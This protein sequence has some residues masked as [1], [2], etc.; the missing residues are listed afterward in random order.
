ME[1]RLGLCLVTGVEDVQAKYILGLGLAQILSGRTK[2]GPL[3]S[4]M[5]KH[6]VCV[7]VRMSVPLQS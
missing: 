3:I 4:E 2:K 7:C 1:K 5:G 6:L